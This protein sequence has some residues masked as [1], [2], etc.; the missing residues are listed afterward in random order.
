MSPYLLL[1]IMYVVSF[2]LP[3]GV[4]F[5][6]VTTAWIFDV[7]LTVCENSIQINQSIAVVLVRIFSYTVCSVV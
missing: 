7:S 2:F 4:F 1:F 3:E 6:L 5:Y